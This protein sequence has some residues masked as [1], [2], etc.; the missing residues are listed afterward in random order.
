MQA[1]GLHLPG[2]VRSWLR[3]HDPELAATRRAGRAA[4]VM[5]ALFALCGQA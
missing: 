3:A 5:P 1:P 4:L 2:R